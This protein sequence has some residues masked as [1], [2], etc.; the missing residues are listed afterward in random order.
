MFSKNKEGTGIIITVSR[1]FGSGGRELG[2]RLSDA[3]RIPCY[4]NEI[5]S[6]IANH[7]GF[8]E[9]YVSRM[10]EK[11]IQQAYP[12]TIGHRFGVA[13]LNYTTQQAI[14]INVEQQKMIE[15]LAA[16]GDCIIIGRCADVILRN[17]KPFTIF[18]YADKSARLRRCIERAAEDENLS[19]V[20]MERKIRGID[21]NRANYRGFYTDTKWGAK[22]NYHLCVNTTGIEIKTIVP[23][24]AEYIKLWFANAENS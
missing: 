19:Q 17:R 21:K 7:Q 15:G 16:Q 1:E 5:I 24:L 22:E 20:E 18:V 12:I 14:K 3:L 9:H 13:G 11:S 6:M 2:K 4:D 23:P 8:D 10:S